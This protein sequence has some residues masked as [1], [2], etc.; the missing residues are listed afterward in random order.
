MAET[1][2]VHVM[3]HGEVHNPERI[4]YGRLQGYG[5][6]EKGRAQSEAVAQAL[7][8]KD[9]VLVVASPL[10][11]AQET[12]APIAA[13]R[14]LDIVTDPNLIES[15]NFFEGRRISPGDGAWRDPRVWWMLRN[16][17]KPSWGEPYK[18]IAAR[19][20]T[21]IDKAR[22]KAAG[23]E[24]VC[25]SHQLPVEILRRFLDDKR[26]PHDPRRRRCNLASLTSFVYDGDQLVDIR[27]NEPAGS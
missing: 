27:Y 20:S 10:Q 7:K 16:P 4:L 3:R 21:A 19:M 5:L 2:T 6:S 14:R 12:A 11:R 8:D 1:T 24:A 17:F 23:H 18:E 15:L 22:A 25:V 13:S 26:L 9:L